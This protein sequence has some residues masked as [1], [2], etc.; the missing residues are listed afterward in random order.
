MNERKTPTFHGVDTWSISTC[1]MA[2][3]PDKSAYLSGA[4]GFLLLQPKPKVL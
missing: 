2:R 3:S 1:S 4:G